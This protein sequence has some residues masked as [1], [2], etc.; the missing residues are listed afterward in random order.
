[1]ES[2]FSEQL[3]KGAFYLEQERFEDSILEYNMA[4]KNAINYKQ[5]RDLNLVLGRLYQKA[6]KPKKAVEAF[7]ASLKLYDLLDPEKEAAAKAALHNNL[8]AAYMTLDIENAISH[9]KSALSL[10]K[11]LASLGQQDFLAHLT[12]THFALAEA[13]LQ[14][15]ALVQAKTHFKEAIKGY[16]QLPELKVIKARAHYQLG[17]IYTEEFNLYDAKIQYTKAL[18]V[19]EK[20]E[21]FGQSGNKPFIAALHN[22]LAITFKSLDEPQKAIASYKK[23]LELYNALCKSQSTV[24]LPYVAA[25]HSS[26]AI[27]FMEIQLVEKAIDETKKALAIY[28]DLADSNPN[29]YTHYLATSLHNLGLFYFELK[30]MDQAEHFFTEALSLRKKIALQAPKAF[31]AD[32][33]ASALN[34][35]EL[36]QY[37]LENQLDISYREKSLV[38]LE[39]VE[40]RLNIFE[41]NRLVIKNMESDCTYYLEY[42]NTINLEELSLQKAKKTMRALQEE[43][44]GTILP[45][46]KMTYQEQIVSLLKTQFEQYPKNEELRHFLA[47]AKNDLGWLYLRLQEPENALTVIQQGESLDK[48][49][50]LLKCNRAHAYLLLGHV[51]EAEILYR[52]LISSHQVIS[53]N[54]KE[55]ITNDLEKLEADGVDTFLISRIKNRIPLLL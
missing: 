44:N 28:N 41:D 11:T 25:T 14:K 23:T 37:L 12:N 2:S 33:C 1:M 26:L 36:Y 24:F 22:N 6:N 7:E 29:D 39:D 32:V 47:I 17:L 20:E 8:A 10:H 53:E 34:L 40:E 38:L 31:N 3:Q 54:Y 9:Y 45:R 42:F 43:I 48:R 46:E 16:E 49:M 35:V 52:E 27:T 15:E 50:D 18:G 19:F 51:K 55:I 4:L 30:A 5:K 13:F 21:S